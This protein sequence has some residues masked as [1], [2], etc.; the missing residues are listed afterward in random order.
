MDLN[1]DGK[2]DLISGNED[3]AVWY[4]ENIG[5]KDE[6]KLAGGVKLESDGKPILA[7]VKK[8]EQQPDGQYK[9][10]VVT[11]GSSELAERYSKIH[12]ADWNNDGFDDMLIGHE[13]GNF[14]LYLNTGDK[15]KPAFGPAKSIKPKEGEFPFRPS[16]YLH[17]W[18]ED[19]KKDLLVGGDEHEI[20]FYKNIG[21][22]KERVFDKP[23][24][25]EADGKPI[26]K[27]TRVRLTVADWNA[28]GKKD[29]IIGDY[30]VKPV[31]NSRKKKKSG[32]IWVFTQK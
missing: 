15:D 10:V 22:E 31:P 14:V 2:P 7:A 29:L 3:G 16:P 21:T 12:L 5:T 13:H 11:P 24:A 26:K 28:D 4:F 27:G 25:I 6:I 18:D 9:Q 20:L 19:G 23:V 8:Y 30:A 32:N 17:D 1:H